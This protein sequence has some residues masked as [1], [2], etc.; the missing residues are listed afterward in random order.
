MENGHP[1]GDREPPKVREAPLS[2]LVPLWITAGLLLCIG[3][4]N[5]EIVGLIADF[6]HSNGIAGNIY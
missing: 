1:S 5:L 2:M 4:F 3:I 6:L